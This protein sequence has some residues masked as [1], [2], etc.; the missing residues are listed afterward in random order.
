M[1]WLVSRVPSG[2]FFQT[3]FP[4]EANPGPIGPGP[5]DLRTG[6][7]ME[8]LRQAVRSLLKRPG[9][10]AV[11]VLTLAI[12][13][14]AN[15]A[16]FSVVNAV[17]LRPLDYHEPNRLVVL[18]EANPQQGLEEGLT[19]GA[20]YLDWRERSRTL[21]GVAAYSYR[22][23]TLTDAQEPVRITSLAVSPSLFQVLGVD[24]GL[25][26]TFL[27]EEEVPGNERLVILSQASWATRF[28]SDPEIIGRT[29]VLD[30][31][32]YTVVGVMPRGFQFPADDPSVE[33]WS[34]LTLDLNAL[35]SRPHR[36]YNAIGRLAPEVSL[37]QAKADMDALASRIEEENPE[38]M[39]GW[40]V[41]L[42]PALEQLTGGVRQTLWFLFGAVMVVLLI[43]CV[44]V[45][46]VLLARSTDTMRDYAIRAAFGAN[47]LALLRRS[48]AESL[49]LAGLG[50]VAGVF[51]AFWGVGVL[52]AVIPANIPR[53]QEIGLD[54][55]VL[56]FALLVS[57]VA[58]LGFGILPSLRMMRLQV[59]PVIQEGGRGA[60]AGR[61]SRRLSN[62]LVG[63]EVALALVLL[64][65]AGLMVKSYMRLNTVSPGFRTEEIVDV[66]VSL[67]ESRYAGMEEQG[68]FFSELTEALRRHPGF[69]DV[70][71]VSSLP[72][73]PLGV[74]FE[75]PFTVEGLDAESPTERP[76]A[77][78]RGT[79]PGYFETMGIPT[80]EGRAFDNLDG[81]NGPPVA[82]INESTSQRYFSGIS[83]IGRKITMPM[84]PPMEIVGV[85]GDV[86]HNGLEA[87]VRPELF[88]PFV[89]LPLS[90]MH[91]VIHTTQDEN[92]LAAAV[93]E[94]VHRID[95]QLPLTRVRT[96]EDI[97]SATMAQPRFN[98]ALLI[99]LA[100]SSI[101][102][103]AVG[104]YGVVSYSV[105][106]RTREIGVRMAMGADQGATTRL[107]AGQVLRVLIWGAAVGIAGALA[108]SRFIAG[109][110]F[111]VAPT[112]PMTYGLVA[113][114]VVAVGLV[115]AIIPALRA[116]RVDPVEALH[117]D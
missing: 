97:L 102:L 1:D 10:T 15:T 69:D 115:A 49:V 3:P 52:R 14:G 81:V 27:P 40:G 46:N 63:S 89:Q 95:P 57:V 56:G 26:R 33:M 2:L 91:I 75:A 94:E 92:L 71:G 72:M 58:G 108:L 24:A 20:T 62:L 30:G 4:R 85:V 48:L 84:I 37:A 88:V 68:Q 109:L 55:T 87:E 35:L 44:N 79:I 101:V 100:F 114:C 13:I 53:A 105:A 66:V 28:G 103:A 82:I 7:R 22:G 25:G 104:V 19:S 39:A 32:P 17:I 21:E 5:V 61:G 70:G 67:P 76:R 98:M 36:M 51:L 111:G 38:E 116:S 106:R 12:A 47:R 8:N 107:V 64:V 45:A 6:R 50:G 83:P 96:I 43:A 110:L 90:E 34:P 78:F 23:F 59:A 11:V 9:M 54:P 31:E 77:D 60:S 41:R 99:G 80:I 93:R 112:D 117:T 113:I 65:G 74:E 73:S 86:H 42:V 18:W 16:I 29:I